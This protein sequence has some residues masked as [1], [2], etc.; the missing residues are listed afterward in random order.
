MTKQ[1]LTKYVASL[2]DRDRQVSWK[3]IIYHGDNIFHKKYTFHYQSNFLGFFLKP[4]SC[5][6]ETQKDGV[7]HN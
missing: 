3:C 4:T 2:K 6:T 7:M 5:T 1:K